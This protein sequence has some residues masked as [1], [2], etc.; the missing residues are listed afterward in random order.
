[1]TGGQPNFTISRSPDPLLVQQAGSEVAVVSDRTYTDF[2]PPAFLLFYDITSDCVEAGPEGCAGVD[3]D[4]DGT[5]SGPGREGSCNLP[6]A[7][8]ACV[9]GAC[10]I[11]QCNLGFGDC[12][13]TPADGCEADTHVAQSTS[14]AILGGGGPSSNA[15]LL[16][17]YARVPAITNCGGCSNVNPAA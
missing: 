6:T 4:W 10:A 17:G 1:W 8:A 5:I 14:P 12:N 9:S 15:D 13:G 11:A 16:P 2:P 3:N 7:K